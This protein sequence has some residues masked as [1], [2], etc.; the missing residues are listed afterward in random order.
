MAASFSD[1]KEEDQLLQ[2]ASQM[3]ENRTKDSYTTTDEDDF[4]IDK[5]LHGS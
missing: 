3:Y 5:L 4:L 1:H 2:H